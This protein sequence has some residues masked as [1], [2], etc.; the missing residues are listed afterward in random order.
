MSPV[1]LDDGHVMLFWAGTDNDGFCRIFELDGSWNVSALGSPLEFDT[2]NGY[3][4]AASLAGDYRV[5][6]FWAGSGDDGFARVFLVEA[7]AAEGEAELAAFAALTCQSTRIDSAAASLSAQA[8]LTCESTR[9]VSGGSDCVGYADL[10]CEGQA[11]TIL[12]EATLEAFGSLA[13]DGGLIVNESSSLIAIA[14][15]EAEGAATLQNEAIL[16]GEAT[17][18]ANAA[19]T[20]LASADLSGEASLTANGASQS[21]GAF[22]VQDPLVLS[23]DPRISNVRKYS[24]LSLG[25]L[26]QPFAINN[27]TFGWNRFA[28]FDL[29]VGVTIRRAILKVRVS[30][31]VAVLTGT[32]VIQIWGQYSAFATNFATSA[33]AISNRDGNRTIAQRSYAID[34]SGSPDWPVG[35]REIE[36]TDVVAEILSHPDRQLFSSVLLH[37]VATGLSA[38]INWN[39]LLDD[40]G[41]REPPLLAITYGTYEAV[42]QFELNGQASLTCQGVIVSVALSGRATMTAV[43][44]V[45][46]QSGGGCESSATLACN[47]GLLVSGSADLAGEASL[48]ATIWNVLEFSSANL[49]GEATLECVPERVAELSASATL[50]A[51]GSKLTGGSSQFYCGAVLRCDAEQFRDLDIS[52]GGDFRDTDV[53]ELVVAGQSIP[54][55]NCSRWQMESFS[56]DY[57][58]GGVLTFHEMRPGLTTSYGTPTYR[59]NDTV[60]MEYRNNYYFRGRVVQTSHDGRNHEEGVTY[61]AHGDQSLSDDVAVENS[62]G[63]PEIILI[64]PTDVAT[65]DGYV[66]RYQDFLSVRA[67]VEI[68]FTEMSSKL[69][70]NGISADYSLEGL[71]EFTAIFDELRITGG[72][73]SALI[74]ITA[75]EPGVKP[76]L[77]PVT[78][79]WI[80]VNLFTTPKLRVQVSSVNLQPHVYTKSCEDRFTALRLKERQ[81]TRVGQR[82]NLSLVYRH[83]LTPL[84]LP[85]EEEEWSIDKGQQPTSETGTVNKFYDVFRTWLVRGQIRIPAGSDVFLGYLP[86]DDR[87]HEKMTAVGAKMVFGPPLKNHGQ[88][89]TPFIPN[90]PTWSPYGV[91]YANAPLVA[92]GNPQ[93][94]GD[95][96]G[97]NPGNIVLI[98]QAASANPC[99]TSAEVRYPKN[100]WEGTA[101]T[102]A[103]ITRE[104]VEWVD[105]GEATIQNA[106]N[107]LR[108]WKDLVIAGDF[109]IEGDPLV[110]FINLQKKVSLYGVKRTGLE[111]VEAMITGYSYRFGKRGANS[112]RFSTDIANLVRF[113]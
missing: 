94:P 111:S 18:E 109:P 90:T 59:L 9:I 36:V 13:V 57:D 16:L 105:P 20:L 52:P 60:T 48:S 44:A 100:G 69:E 81:D 86:R 113:K 28:E 23:S 62:G 22:Y 77:D 54:F 89:D 31:Q 15:V 87:Q 76:Y 5:V 99:D 42:E 106:E 91:V 82:Q 79:R 29:P 49:S 55:G 21:G 68:L 30:T 46:S 98:Y 101:Y 75:Y 32:P 41:D 25:S 2:T 58:A 14:D 24:V 73:L 93:V 27:N 95:A 66:G 85:E 50:S 53:F 110:E 4:H 11:G 37:I 6:N 26:T 47:G 35:Y 40:G 51:S 97:P 7:P 84:W 10:E 8:D 108:L 63:C 70:A 74:A 38:D 83:D 88:A 19:S 64:P 33:E 12:G 96:V 92:A 45:T 17:L 1:L 72:F 43:A 56:N 67:A 103:G 65:I 3:F 102:E 34:N 78:N 107:R 39:S 104:K 71:A 80:F 112:L 61:I